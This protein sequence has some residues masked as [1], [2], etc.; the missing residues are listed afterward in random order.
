VK[1]TIDKLIGCNAIAKTGAFKGEEWSDPESMKA[2][3]ELECTLAEDQVKGAII[4]FLTGV[5]EVL[6]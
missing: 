4:A 3:E 6:E 5:L 1:S 2:I